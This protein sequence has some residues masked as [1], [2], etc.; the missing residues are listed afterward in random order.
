MKTIILVRHAKSDCTHPLQ[1]DFERRLNNRGKKDAAEMAQSLSQKNIYPEIFISSNAE[2]AVETAGYFLREFKRKGKELRLIADLYRPQIHSFYNAVESIDNSFHCAILFS[3]N[4][5]IAEFV[6]DLE[7]M[8]V[9]DIPACGMYG[10]QLITYRW[11]ELRLCKKKF[12][13]FNF[14]RNT[15]E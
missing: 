2:R 15:E 14:P 4:P 7:C 8:P 9:P 10:L 3:H 11:E 1:S 6:N 13:F 5:G 12:L